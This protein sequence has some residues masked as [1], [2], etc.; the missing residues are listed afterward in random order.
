MYKRDD[1]Y[2]AKIDK[3]YLY[4]ELDTHY[5]AETDLVSNLMSYAITDD[6]EK[7]DTNWQLPMKN[8]GA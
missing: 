1:H 7:Q 5:S 4:K 6:L 2:Y 8:F 3:G